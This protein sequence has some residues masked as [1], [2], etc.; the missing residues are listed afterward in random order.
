VLRP[1]QF[2]DAVR[3][4]VSCQVFDGLDN[5]LAHARRQFSEILAR[6]FLPLNAKGHG[7]S[8]PS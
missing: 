3:E 5:P 2:F 8:A 1:S 6:G 4:R 7:V